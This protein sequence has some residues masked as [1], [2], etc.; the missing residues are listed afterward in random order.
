M[1]P[2]IPSI[3]SISAHASIAR[4]ENATSFGE[5]DAPPFPPRRGI[6]GERGAEPPWRDAGDLV[7]VRRQVE[8]GQQP[9][10]V[11]RRR[12]PGFK[13]A[14]HRLHRRHLAAALP[15]LADETGGDEGLADI[16]AGRSDK[17]GGH[18]RGLA[19]NV[20]ADI[21][22][23]AQHLVLGMRGGE[24]EAQAGGSRRH[25]GRPDRGHQKT[26]RLERALGGERGPGLAQNHRHDRA[27]GLRQ[28][29]GAGE[30][31]GPRQGLGHQARV[32]IDDVER[33]GGGGD[34]RR[35]Q[36]GGINERTRPRHQEV[37]HGLGRA[38]IAAVAPD[39]LRQCPHL[40]GH[41]PGGTRG[42][43]RAASV[44]DHA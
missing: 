40:E 28:P 41:A 39:R 23:E 42:R 12:A 27:R 37:D 17:D 35:R 16:G 20:S 5:I 3:S 6:G 43:D 7:R 30:G 1:T 33:G 4:R 2:P 15:E 8:R 24:G 10:R 18:A 11:A 38:D 31:P 32:T 9:G 44:A 25:G 19:K 21:R 26:L 36:A 29:G 34:G 13:A 14:H 22:C